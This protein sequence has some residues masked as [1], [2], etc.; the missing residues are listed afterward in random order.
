MRRR[1]AA[2]RPAPP[3]ARRPYPLPFPSPSLTARR[4]LRPAAVGLAYTTLGVLDPSRDA[5][6]LTVKDFLHQPPLAPGHALRR[7]EQVVKIGEGTFSLI[8]HLGDGKGSPR[9]GEPKSPALAAVA[10]A[11]SSSGS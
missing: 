1:C 7:S 4:R 10:G 8:S 11:S 3:P 2:P 5:A 9:K 6:T